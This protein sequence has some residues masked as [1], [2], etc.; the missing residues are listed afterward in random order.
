LAVLLPPA[1]EKKITKFKE[2]V[3]H[4]VQEWSA[5]ASGATFALLGQ[6]FENNQRG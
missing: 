4:R 3:S 5:T 6:W 2:L 1:G